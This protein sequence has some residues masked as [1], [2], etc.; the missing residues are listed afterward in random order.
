MFALTTCL[1]GSVYV[2]VAF[3][4]TWSER[5]KLIALDG[6]QEDWFG[7]SVA[8]YGNTIVVGAIQDNSKTGERCCLVI[9]ATIK[10]F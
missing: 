6:V 3:D 2:Y 5:I 10:Y 9:F 4:G 8:V 1:L 7:W